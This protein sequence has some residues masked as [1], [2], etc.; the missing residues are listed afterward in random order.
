[1]AAGAI[2]L[3]GHVSVVAVITIL[4]GTSPPDELPPITVELVVLD[5]ANP[6]PAAPAGERPPDNIQF[7][8]SV[9]AMTNPPA[10][11]VTAP[12]PNQSASPDERAASGIDPTSTRMVGAAPPKTRR[13]DA[14][15]DL[16]YV[17]KL[18]PPP[19]AAMLLES[20][21]QPQQESSPTTPFVTAVA[22]PVQFE[23]PKQIAAI[24]PLEL[25]LAE[26]TKP[27]PPVR[28]PQPKPLSSQTERLSAPELEEPEL[29]ADSTPSP[30]PSDPPDPPDP[31]VIIATA[32]VSKLVDPARED[33]DAPTDVGDAHPATPKPASTRLIIEAGQ[34][35]PES[36]GSVQVAGAAQPIPRP[37]GIT[38]GVQV[39]AGN[40][41]PKYPLAARQHGLEGRVLLRVEVDDAGN[42]HRVAVTKSSGHKI[43][44]EAARR[45]AGKWQFL[46][47]LV[48]G[49]PAS[50]AIDVP[51]VFRLD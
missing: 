34:A 36:T 40:R 3:V 21:T 11:S 47:A 35:E 16:G 29:D 6:E 12:A 20:T 15:D 4:E 43:L 45:A 39:I 9:M 17:S 32:E 30:D 14:E 33:G 51:I 5:E 25:P 1:M 10:P 50:G 18:W 8:T 46:P 37:L 24:T 38:R 26:P 13:P 41:P 49:E 2:S 23:T 31:G 7:D 19:A 22:A 44:D 27:T 48:G 28:L 42:A